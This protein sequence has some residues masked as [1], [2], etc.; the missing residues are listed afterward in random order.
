MKT[1]ELEKELKEL[2]DEGVEI[3]TDVTT[4]KREK[5]TLGYETWYS[6]A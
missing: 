1:E 6:K 2:I 5:F 3:A 4:D